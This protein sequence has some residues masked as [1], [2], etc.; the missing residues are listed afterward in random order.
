MGDYQKPKLTIPKELGLQP[1]PG[2]APIGPGPC[3]PAGAPPP[4]SKGSIS[5]P[6]QVGKGK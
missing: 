6:K 2:P 1:R 4:K 3:I 5:Y